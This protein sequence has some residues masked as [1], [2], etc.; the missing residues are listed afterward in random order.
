L[1]Y[2]I[3]PF[4]DEVLCD[5]SP[6][7]VCDV[8]LGQPY[9]WKHHVIYESRPRS[10]IVT[11]GGHLYRIP[12]VVLTIVP[13]KQCHKVISHTAKFILFTIC[14]KGEQK[15]TATTAALAQ[16]LS[17]QQK[18]I[19]EEKEDIV[20]S[21]TMVPTHCPVKPRYNRLVEQIQPRQQ[22]VVTTF[23]K[24]SNT[25][26]PARQ[27]THQDSD[28]TNAFPSPLGTQCNGDHCFLRRED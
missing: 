3:Q 16:D 9:M 7:D 21:P 10:V 28:S 15:D 2:D 4:K 20:S 23:N 11:L 27:A 17:I 24:L 18:Q 8:L 5:V 14:S 25:T 1:S 13:P 12:E 26:S 19:A 22:Q 6:L